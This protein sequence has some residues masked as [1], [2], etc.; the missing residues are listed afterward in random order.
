MKLQ[1]IKFLCIKDLAKLLIVLNKNYRTQNKLLDS[2][3]FGTEEYAIEREIWNSSHRNI[4]LVKRRMR[5]IIRQQ[6]KAK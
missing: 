6:R 2:C 1:D 4:S 3:E 5:N